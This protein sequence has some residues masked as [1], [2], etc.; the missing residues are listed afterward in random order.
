MS[1]RRLASP[2]AMA[3]GPLGIAVIFGFGIALAGVAGWRLNL[4]AIDRQL[5]ETRAGLKKLSLSG[6]IPPNQDVMEYLSA[7]DVAMEER[8]RSWVRAV[9]APPAVDAASS[10]DPQLFFQEELHDVQRMLERLTAARSLPVPEQLGFPKELPPSDTVP[11]LLIQLSLIKETAQLILDQGVAA[12]TSFKLEDPVSVPEARDEQEKDG[13]VPPFLVRFPVRI[14]LTASLPQLMKIYAAIER[15]APLI[16]VRAMR[17]SSQD[18]ADRLLDVELVV[19][20]HVVISAAEESAAPDQAHR[21]AS[22]ASARRAGPSGPSHGGVS[23][24]PRQ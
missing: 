10:A 1:D 13:E 24:K 23:R 18:A 5:A 3:V 16:D 19:A 6:N 2:R 22:N 11:R 8:Y 21:S 20:R 17:V 7:R 14:R 15:V 4:Q 12:L 9:T